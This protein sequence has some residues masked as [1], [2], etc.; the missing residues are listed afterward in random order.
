M[1]HPAVPSHKAVRPTAWIR[2]QALCDALGLDVT[3]ACEIGQHT[4]SFKFRAAYHLAA[5]VPHPLIITASSG[6]FG[7][8]LAYACKLLGKACIVVMPTTSAKVKV[9]AVKRHGGR[10]EYVDTAVTPRA[11]RV[12]ELAAEHP[13]AYVASAYDDLLVIAG[14]SSL[15]AEIAAHASRFDVVVAPVGGGGLTAGIIQGIR[16]SGA[17]ITVIGAEPAMANDAARSLA[18]GAV[19]AHAVEPQ[20][21]ADGARTVS[22]GRHNFPVLQAGMAGIIEVEESAIREGLRRLH[23]EAG[24]R[25]EPTGALALGA[26]LTAP[27]RFAG[28]RVCVVVSGGNVDDEV[29][30]GLLRAHA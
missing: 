10:V 26:V 1:P 19:V 7:Q 12:A 3:L 29:F 8:A 21:I 24:L 17:A 15:G 11:R 25:A 18:T 23:A 5:N 22:L 13:E 20:T 28:Q 14:N 6:N 4:G 30:E 2:P 9:E 27:E 16:A